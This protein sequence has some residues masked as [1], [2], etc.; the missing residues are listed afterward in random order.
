MQKAVPPLRSIQILKDL[1]GEGRPPGAAGGSQS[2]KG[3]GVSATPEHLEILVPRARN[4]LDALSKC[5]TQSV[6]HSRLSAVELPQRENASATESR[7]MEERRPGILDVVTPGQLARA[8][9]VVP[10]RQ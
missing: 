7:Y 10:R 4:G 9:Q 3:D 6:W 5:E 1:D 2:Q 8:E